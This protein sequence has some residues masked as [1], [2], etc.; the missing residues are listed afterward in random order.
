[1]TKHSKFPPKERYEKFLK[2]FSTNDTKLNERILKKMI[3]WRE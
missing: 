2:M 3:V 1:M